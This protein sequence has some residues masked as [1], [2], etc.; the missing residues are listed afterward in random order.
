MSVAWFASRWISSGAAALTLACNSTGVGNPPSAA[1]VSMAIVAD[2]EST[3]P[4][5]ADA[6]ADTSLPHGS[7]RR[8]LLVLGSVHWLP[9]DDAVSPVISEGPFI[10]D[11]VTGESRPQ[12]PDAPTPAGGFCGFDAPL[13][14]NAASAEL[15]GR[16]LFFSGVR[17]D[18]V[19]FLL[20]SNMRAT[21]RARATD[22]E[23]WGDGDN[24]E[25]IWA[26]RPNRWASNAE[27]DASSVTPWGTRRAVVIDVD[28]NPLLYAAIRSRLAGLS[29]VFLDRDRDGFL[30]G[31]EREAPPIGTGLPETE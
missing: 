17:A 4:P 2:D 3:A 19:P 30:D 13:S 26:M 31:N 18:G 9:C 8:A 20:F 7:L 21:L 23:S 12:L 22:G 29:D 1:S 14:A 28:R 5:A 6:G 15:A 11:L 16:S 25:L 10:V 24:L 27:L